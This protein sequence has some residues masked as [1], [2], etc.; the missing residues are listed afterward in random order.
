MLYT[1]RFFFSSK[2]SLFHNANFFGSHIIHIL[3][4]ECAEIKKN[5]SG[6]KGLNGQSPRC[7]SSCKY[8][9]CSVGVP[10]VK[11]EKPYVSPK[12]WLI[13]TKLRGVIFLTTGVYINSWCGNPKYRVNRAARLTAC[14]AVWSQLNA[15]PGL[16]LLLQRFFSFFFFF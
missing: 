11:Q 5:N 8:I 2:C 13:L 14:S 10:R 6:A 3:Y 16:I 7:C 1:L 15:E 12:D 9:S 4:T